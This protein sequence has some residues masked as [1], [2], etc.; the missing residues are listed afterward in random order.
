CCR[1][2]GRRG[3][4]NIKS[5]HGCAIDARPRAIRLLLNVW[6]MPMA[7]EIEINDAKRDADVDVDTPLLW[8][9]RDVLGMTGT[10]VVCGQAVC[11]CARVDNGGVATRS[12]I[13][14][15]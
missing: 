1:A 6:E 8:V 4:R 9:C 7:F 15:V 3:A 2:S 5:E 13:T 14:T 11:C 10:K 12:C